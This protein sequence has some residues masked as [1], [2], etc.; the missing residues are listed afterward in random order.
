MAGGRVAISDDTI[1]PR[2]LVAAVGGSFDADSETGATVG[3]G[4]MVEVCTTVTEARVLDGYRLELAFSDG[5]REAVDLSPRILGSGGVFRALEDP[6][7]FRQVRVDP[8]LGTIVWPNEADFCPELLRR[9][10]LGEPVP[11]AERERV[12]RPTG[13]DG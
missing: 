7:F 8:Q 5:V 1:K 11:T 13:G 9:W 6:E 3:R 2:P 10:A 12:E 4:F